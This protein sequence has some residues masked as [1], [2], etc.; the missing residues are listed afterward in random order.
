VKNLH[1]LTT[2][3]LAVEM[4]RPVSTIQRWARIRLIPSI[5]AGWRTRLY[6]PEA[7]RRALEKLSVPEIG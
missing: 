4:R 6:D 3:E 7:V 2:K 1:L 5:Y